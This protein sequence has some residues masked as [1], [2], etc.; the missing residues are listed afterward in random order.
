[1]K[2]IEQIIEKVFEN[3]ESGEAPNQPAILGRLLSRLLGGYLDTFSSHNYNEGDD[4]FDNLEYLVNKVDNDNWY[5]VDQVTRLGRDYKDYVSGGILIYA[6]AMD[7]DITTSSSD[8][9]Q[10]YSQS[11]YMQKQ[12]GMQ[13]H[14]AVTAN[15]FY[16][17][18]QKIDPKLWVNITGVATDTLYSGVINANPTGDLKTHLDQDYKESEIYKIT[19]KDK[20]KHVPSP[21]AMAGEVEVSLAGLR[22]KQSI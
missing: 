7:G 8:F 12:L 10:Y 14:E 13:A 19:A 1:M 18:S 16:K 21:E 15:F 4:I 20:S 3:L 11:D 17:L 9:F 22:R 2:L 5:T 6:Y